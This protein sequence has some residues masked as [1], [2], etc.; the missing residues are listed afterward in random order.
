MTTNADFMRAAFPDLPLSAA[1]WVTGFPGCPYAAPR[2][3]W[4]GWNVR[5]GR[6]LGLNPLWN[7]YLVVSSFRP[8]ENGRIRRRKA[9]FAALHLVMVNDIGPKV[10]PDAILLP[11]SAMVETSP[12]NCQGWYLI[13]PPCTERTIAERLIDGLIGA[14]LTADGKD[15]GM[16]GVNRYGRLPVGAN[17]KA[18]IVESEGGPFF[19]RLVEWVPDRRYSVAQIAAAYDIDLAP[20]PPPRPVVRAPE[21]AADNLLPW[22]EALGWYFTQ[23]GGDWHAVRCPWADEHT[24]GDV[25]GTQ[26]RT[27]AP[28]NNHAGAFRCFHG[29][30]AART[31]KDLHRFIRVLAKSIREAA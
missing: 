16:S 8:D 12:G 3:S 5:R 23:L 4:A 22:F 15:P 25:S 21:G 29:H 11:L 9:Q 20:K 19:H 28:E 6:P 7:N 2:E 1:P 14:G 17:H 27:P 10:R 13:D 30:C 24:N 31:V 26:Y 18:R